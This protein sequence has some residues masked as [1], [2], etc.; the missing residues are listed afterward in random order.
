MGEIKILNG[1][2]PVQ[3]TALASRTI[4]V[5]L[6]SGGRRAYAMNKA[7]KTIKKVSETEKETVFDIQLKDGV[8]F[9]GQSTPKTFHELVKYE[10]S[11]EADYIIYERS[12]DEVTKKNK[13][14]IIVLSILALLI[15]PGLFMGEGNKSQVSRQ[16]SSEMIEIGQTIQIEEEPEKIPN[17]KA[18]ALTYC[19]IL[20]K[21]NARSPSTVDFP[22]ISDMAISY[23]KRIYTVRSY[24]DAQNGFGATVRQ[25]YYCKMHYTGTGPIDGLELLGFEFVD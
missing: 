23:D 21:Q 18:E 14:M 16:P 17:R 25:N 10:G 15:V 20:V 1:N 19:Q 3:S 4:V 22:F 9:R 8:K 12:A 7:I 24:F 13:R 6:Q 5:K 11:D 2:L